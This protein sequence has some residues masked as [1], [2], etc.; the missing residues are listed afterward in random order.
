VERI[1]L[2]GFYAD[3]IC[4]ALAVPETWHCIIQWAGCNEVL[5]WSQEDSHILAVET[6][7]KALQDLKEGQSNTAKHASIADKKF[8]TLHETTQ[9]LRS[10]R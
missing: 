10:R 6:A 9:R 7:D 5:F 4:D 1:N 8:M 3:I 2:D